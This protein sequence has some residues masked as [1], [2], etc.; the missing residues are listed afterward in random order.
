MST[1]PRRSG[2]E[3]EIDIAVKHGPVK[4]M[5][6]MRLRPGSGGIVEAVRMI[7]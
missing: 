3:R 6:P 5:A 7:E 1:Y 4:A 2:L